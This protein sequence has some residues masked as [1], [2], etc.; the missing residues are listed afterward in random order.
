MKFTARPYSYY[1]LVINE[2]L[3]NMQITLICIVLYMQIIYKKI[4]F[5]FSFLL[6]RNLGCF[7]KLTSDLLKF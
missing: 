2:T 5:L 3:I 4:K 6:V 1:N 7:L